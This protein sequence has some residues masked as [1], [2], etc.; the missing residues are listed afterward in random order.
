MPPKPGLSGKA[1]LIGKPMRE[2]EGRGDDG[3]NTVCESGGAARPPLHK[4]A[5]T[6]LGQWDDLPACGAR[7]DQVVQGPWK[8]R[9]CLLA[10]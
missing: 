1:V 2:I 5:Y 3:G 9:A 4:R 10:F 6:R 8:T 7:A